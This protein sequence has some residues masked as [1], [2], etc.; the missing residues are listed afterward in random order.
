M[1]GAL[2]PFDANGNA[3]EDALF[4]LL[5]QSCESPDDLAHWRQAAKAS[6]QEKFSMEVCGTVY[7]NRF[8]AIMN[9]K[10]T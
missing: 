6:F 1:A 8:N 10:Q 7:E 2:I 3:D 4:R 5:K 9:G